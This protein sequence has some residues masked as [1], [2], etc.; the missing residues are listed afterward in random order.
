M[1]RVKSI[2][3]L[4]EEVKDYDYVLCNDAPLTTALNNRLDKAQLGPFAMTPIQFASWKAVEFT[5]EPIISEINLVNKIAE[6]THFS[7]KYVHGEVERFK[8]ALRYTKTPRMGRK[9]SVVWEEFIQYNTVEKVLLNIDDAAKRFFSA[10][11]VAVIGSEFFN[12]LDKHVLPEINTYAEIE[13]TVP[14]ERYTIP[15]VHILGND[16]S[17]AECAADLVDKCSPMDVAIVMDTNGPIANSIK[18]ALYKRSISFINS[19][20]MKDLASVRNFLEFIQLALSFT[21]IKV[22][23]ARELI[24]AYGG[25]IDSKYDNHY[26]S[27]FRDSN[28]S[29]SKETT[30]LLDLMAN[31]ESYSFK[32]ACSISIPA[33]DR[34][35]VSMLL[36]QMG[37]VGKV[38]EE[39]K[40]V[41][42]EALD[43]LTYAVNN[44]NDLTHNEQI[45]ETEKKGVLLVDCKN[46]VYIDRPVVVYTGIGIDWAVDLWS[47]D[48]IDPN[49][50]PDL[51]DIYAKRF[52]ALIQQ[53]SVRFYL[54]NATKD[55]KEAAPCRYFEEYMTLTG[56]SIGSITSF[57]QVSEQEPIRGIWPM[58]VKD[59][60]ASDD[61]EHIES[62][63]VP[64]YFSKSSY[65]TYLTCPMKYMLSRLTRSPDNSNTYLGTKI[66]DYAEFRISY[67]E[68]AKELGTD[69]CA[70]MVT[71]ECASLN[72]PD[73]YEMDRS[74]ISASVRAID[75][76]IEKIGVDPGE[77]I[78]I[79]DNKV[80]DNIFLA[81]QNLDHI[82]EHSE[83]KI[84]SKDI[85]MD[86]RLDLVWDGTI[87]DFKTGK[88]STVTD[89]KNSMELPED[90]ESAPSGTYIE[91][92]PLLYLCLLRILE[93]DSKDEFDLF[94]TRHMYEKLLLNQDVAI[95]DCVRT[96]IVC[97]DD[98]RIVADYLNDVLRRTIEGKDLEPI[99]VYHM[100]M[101]EIGSDRES[102]P[103]DDSIVQKISDRFNI[104]SKTGKIIGDIKK[105]IVGMITDLKDNLAL[106]YIVCGNTLVIR[107]KV[108]EGFKS[109]L[110]KDLE[111]VKRNFFLPN[112]SKGNGF[113]PRE[114]ENCKYCEFRDMC[115]V[116]SSE[117]DDSDD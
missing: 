59:R 110:L 115:L 6:A 27:K 79:P 101:E 114:S 12:E 53:G 1:D 39:D 56:N 106:D 40:M 57:E 116:D 94:Y 109:R 63:D 55:G 60:S 21:T 4:Y 99:D 70:E 15:L 30:K 7:L 46:S 90:D 81:S 17:I 96:V 107:S 102:W 105:G 108:I 67:P 43:D 44:I 48:Y 19:L 80:T 20:T 65:N 26:L 104:K 92:Q 51:E 49:K 41:T 54:V 68:K 35:S 97:D 93:S 103:D 24:S 76:F 37:F 82:S 87:F 113:I 42:Q 72:S 22:K 75:E 111:D 31:I 64:E 95:G 98:E 5:G 77:L 71:K 74:M 91:C 45:P 34:S 112:D 52:N 23:D 78:K 11:K 69:R 58:T 33:K 16:R 47:I 29:R 100:C 13:L 50:I 88:S 117:G 18:S 62:H 38:G 14:G 73:E 32:N 10:Y 9:S 36:D 2:D 61:G 8:S 84:T 28:I 85:G 86:G 89:I 83:R 66:H 25:R 3:E